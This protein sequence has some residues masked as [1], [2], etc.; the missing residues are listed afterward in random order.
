MKAFIA[1]LPLFLRKFIVDFVETGLVAVL[2]LTLV[3]DAAAMAHTVLIALGVAALAACRR[4][5]PDFFAFL[6]DLFSVDPA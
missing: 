1:K 4:A 3:G 2:G 5:L 6:A